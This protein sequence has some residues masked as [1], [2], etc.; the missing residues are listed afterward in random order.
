MLT[1]DAKCSFDTTRTAA[2][3]FQHHA[4]LSPSVLRCHGLYAANGDLLRVGG[5]VLYAVAAATEPLCGRVDEILLRASDG[6]PFG[7][8]VCKGNI[9]KNMTL[10]YRFPAVTA[11]ESDYEFISVKVSI[12]CTWSNV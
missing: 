1:K 5:W 9:D 3:G 11:M 10:P 6:A 7:V 12:R 8:L 2:S 4:Q